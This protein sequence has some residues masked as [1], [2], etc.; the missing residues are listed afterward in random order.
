LDWFVSAAHTVLNLVEH[1]NAGWVLPM[2]ALKQSDI[3]DGL[4]SY[5]LRW[6]KQFMRI[7]R[8]SYPEEFLRDR[9]GDMLN[10]E[11][12]EEY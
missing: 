2:R 4:P 6:M 5:S 10:S 3:K 12:E 8:T 1:G 7:G 11:T 9:R